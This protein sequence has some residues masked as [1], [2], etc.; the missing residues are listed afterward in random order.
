MS[1]LNSNEIFLT[2]F[3]ILKSH[4]TM[5]FILLF[6]VIVSFQATAEIF[7]QYAKVTLDIKNGTIEDVF[8]EI[9]N[10][11]D[12][13]IFYK[14]DQIDVTKKLSVK[15][16]E[17][18]LSELLDGLLPTYKASYTVLDKI[19]VI[20]G[21]ETK[22]QQQYTIKGKVIDSETG[23]P[24]P[25]V[26]II[27]KGQNI[28]T[29]TDVEGNFSLQSNQEETTLSISFIGYAT[30]E[31]AASH[32]S[33]VQV[34]L[35]PDV[36]GLE[37]VVVIGYGIE[38]KSL[39]TGAISSVKSEEIAN[40]SISM[41][42]QALQ[43]R[44]AGVMVLPSSG[45]PGAEMKVRIRGAGSNGNSQPLFIV[46]GVKTRNINVISP[47]DIESME[48]L[49]DAAS[50]A[51][52]G[53]EG[54]NGV[55]II[56]TKTG[57]KG[58]S[59]ISYSFQYGNQTAGNLPEMM[60][61][62]QYI[63]FMDDGIVSNVQASG[64]DT[65][66]LDEIFNPAPMQKH[67]LSFSGGSEAT[68]F[69]TTFSYYNQDGILGGEKANYERISGRLNVDHQVNKMVKVGSKI[70]YTNTNRAALPED[71]E[72]NGLLAG[73][74]GI[75][76]LTPTH[77]NDTASMPISI[78][79]L[80]RDGQPVRQTEDG[81]YY[82]ISQYVQGE[83]VNP[84]LREDISRG[85]T[86]TDNIL[87][88]FFMDFSP[89]KGLVFTSRIGIDYTH[90]N[91]HT[92]NPT[93]Y[94]SSERNNGTTSVQ[95]DGYT[96]NSWQWENFVSY[97]LNMS[98]SNL[99]IVGGMS[100]ESLTHRIL[101]AQSDNMFVEDD[102]FDELVYTAEPLGKARVEGNLFEEKI[103]SYFGRVSYNIRSKYMLQ[104]SLRYD[105]ASTSLL[106]TGNNW[107]AFPSFSAGWVMS[108][109]EFFPRDVIPFFK[110][111][112]SWG[113]NGSLAN[114][115]SA[116]QEYT[117]YSPFQGLSQYAYM[118]A[119]INEGLNYPLPGG[120][121]ISASEP[122]LLPNPNLTWET[123]QQ[124]DIGVDMRLLDGKVSFTA[125]YFIKQTK[126]LLGLVPSP[127]TAGN[128]PP[129]VNVG[130]VENRGFEFDLGFRN[131]EGML[132]YQI[133]L[134]AS[135]LKNE[136]TSLDVDAARLDGMRVGTSWTG[137]TTFEEGEPIWYFRGFKTDGYNADGSPNF[138]D[139]S[140]PNGEPDGQITEDDRTNIGSPHPNLIYG[141]N[142]NLEMMGVDLNV[143]V[144]GMSGNEIIMGWVRSD[145]SEVNKPTV[146]YNNTAIRQVSPDEKT[147]RSDI[148]VFDG[149]Y[150]RIKQVQLGYTLPQNWVNRARINSIRLYV[151]LEDYFTFTKYEGMDPEAGSTED[152]SIGIDKGTYPIPRK[153]LFG[154][155]VSF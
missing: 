36:M 54:A 91:K 15:A 118:D 52:Y 131:M 135:T 122:G 65:D 120:G 155:N 128:L 1:K 64:Y 28:G 149:S 100:A 29:I 2:K 37:E 40:T 126:D 142:L 132:K 4:L 16:E 18:L 46:D 96:Q 80:V 134:N 79:Q 70:S 3:F 94:Y 48:V 119:I 138:V 154:L 10:Q 51:I 115:R 67:H 93:Y 13:N 129:F 72:F 116:W 22:E 127:A 50:S 82:G 101:M 151:S 103:A 59:L 26:N 76:P 123:S 112:G 104:A 12:F 105:G 35:A 47:N 41:A 49:K 140:G 98:Q 152:S 57:T 90:Q 39:V 143:F 44:T 99:S 21:Q 95:D 150:I 24:L 145:R 136:V 68:S 146:F 85:N 153:A 63:D 5:K 144:Q 137:A 113:Q 74:L 31:V 87:G 71:H 83:L 117:D 33:V 7:S 130:D 55:V 109:E 102:L 139:V 62:Q 8:T 147:Y 20:R 11:S 58:K 92:W 133:N 56:T 34:Q 73:A 77:Y 114:L 43:G 78:R 42:E 106:P 38:K 45:S 84:L 75:D 111:R 148:L 108:E 141:G 53:A 81:R 107:G 89:I 14:V 69:Y 19:I 125:D 23:E 32:T 60:N 61:A 25:G 86:V 88:N 9:E 27:V 17:K 66:W 121:Y 97:T 6:M 110:I 30:Q 124:T